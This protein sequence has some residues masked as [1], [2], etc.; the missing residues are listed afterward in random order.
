MKFQKLILTVLMICTG[1]AAGFSV[2]SRTLI[3]FSKYDQNLKAQYTEPEEGYV[4]NIDGQPQVVLGYR[5]YLLENWR[6]DLN[7]TSSG[8][9]NRIYSYCRPVASQ[10]FETVLGARIHFPNWRNNSYAIIRPP[11]PIR[12]YD[13]NGQYANAE[14]GVMPNVAEIKTM[15]IWV[16]GRNYRYGLAVRLIDRY[17]KIHEFFLGWIHF[18]GWR[19]LVWTNPNYTETVI[20]KSLSREP[21]YPYDIPFMMF[22]SLVIYRPS[23]QIGGDF[24]VYFK[25]IE[26]EYTPYIV[27]TTFTD[28]IRDEEVWGI[29]TAKMKRRKA[30]EEKR[31][32]EDLYLYQQEKRRIQAAKD[33]VGGQRTGTNR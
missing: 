8:M 28:D 14:N 10:R 32:V 3:D 18:D 33:E 12:I 30:I 4:T 13:E 5:D 21:L 23:D 7:E 29:I 27:D 19:K 24:V 2:I 6:V 20:A 15:S 11:F 26:M 9:A 22:D 1:T 31:M 16:S 25:S 17:S